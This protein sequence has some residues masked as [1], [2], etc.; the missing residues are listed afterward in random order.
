[1]TVAVEDLCQGT[2]LSIGCYGRRI[3]QFDGEILHS[4]DVDLVRPGRVVFFS[5]DAPILDMIKYDDR[6]FAVTS[7][8]DVH[9]FSGEEVSSNVLS[10]H[11]GLFAGIDATENFLA[12]GHDLSHSVR[13]VDPNTLSTASTVPLPGLI[14][15]VAS[16][17]GDR[18]L[19]NDDTVFS[20]LDPRTN[21]GPVRS[22]PLPSAPLVSIHAAGKIIVSCEDRELRVF[23]ERKLKS[24]LISTKPATK[25]GAIALYAVD[26]VNVVC[27][28]SDESVV[29][30]NTELDVGQFKRSKYLGESPWVSRPVVIGDTVCLL[31]RGG[32]LHR[33]AD[34]FG[35]L[36]KSQ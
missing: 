30:V 14:C 8:G 10:G 17:P 22:N 21:E 15:S 27:V 26:G 7:K 31:T 36:S 23:D 5:A 4:T 19:V 9:G 34:V 33:F 11:N 32:A 12:V 18:I 25:N 1:M 28:G 29:L 16:M 3:A 20:I 13:F 24:P 35:F 2:S 6:L